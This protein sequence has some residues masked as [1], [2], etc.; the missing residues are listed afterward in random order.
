[1][2][3]FTSKHMT[4]AKSKG[5]SAAKK[6]SPLKMSDPPVS[7]DGRRKS[8]PLPP[9]DTRRK[10]EPMR[11]A[12]TITRRKQEFMRPA[13]TR[14]KQELYTSSPLKKVVPPKVK[15]KT[16]QDSTKIELTKRYTEG[17]DKLKKNR[18]AHASRTDI[19]VNQTT[20]VATARPY[21]KKY[22]KGKPGSYDRIADGSN[23]VVGQAKSAKKN[24]PGSNEALY[25]QYKKD[26]TENQMQRHR[27]ADFYNLTAG[28]KKV[29]TEADKKTLM[30][31]G[32]AVQVK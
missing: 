25:R 19:D 23:K 24:N 10:Q 30:K 12:D 7:R 32:K 14:R 26:S 15:P 4:M 5:A 3:P 27:T 9:A 2:N 8:E 20:G 1:M 17:V 29:M 13:D 6:C 11:P 16:T 28:K 22:I 21:E 31:L 18:K